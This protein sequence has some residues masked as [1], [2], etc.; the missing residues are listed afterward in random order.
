MKTKWV[1][2]M[3]VFGF[4]AQ[5]IFAAP[6]YFAGTGHWYEW[7]QYPEPDDDPLDWD[8]MRDLVT[9]WTLFG[10]PGHLATIHSQAENDFINSLGRGTGFFGAFQPVGS[11]E[12]AGN[13]QWVTGEPW[14]YSNWS[15]GNPS[16][17]GNTGNEDVASMRLDG[18]WNDR[19]GI[20]EPEKYFTDVFV[21]YPVPKPG[22]A[23]RDGVV[24]AD[25]YGSVQFHFGNVYLI[26]GGPGDADINGMVSADDYG[27]VQLHFGAMAGMGS[28]P[29]PEPA[30]L[31]LLG[32]GGLVMLRRRK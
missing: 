28:V 5:Q 26:P 25:D 20:V 6:V 8:E 22:D 14:I 30:T 9:T 18:E 13:W 11:P 2:G 10:V 16:N 19:T 1:I 12:P 24:S 4:C 31:S 29:I 21:E 15:P 32:I 17:S 23:N 7:I 27:S 3:M